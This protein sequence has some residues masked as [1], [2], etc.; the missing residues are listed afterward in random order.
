M[1]S[2]AI[3]RR[4]EISYCACRHKVLGDIMSLRDSAPIFLS[5][6]RPLYFC[7]DDTEQAFLV[8]IKELQTPNFRSSQRH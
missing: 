2:E 1:G 8:R 6:L 3:L 7:A 5:G 4:Y